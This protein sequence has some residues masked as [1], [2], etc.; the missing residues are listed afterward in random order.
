VAGEHHVDEVERVCDSAVI[1]G[2]GRVLAA[3]PLDD[4]R[5]RVGGWHVEVVTGSDRLA[6]ALTAVGATVHAEDGRLRVEGI[7]TAQPIRDAIADLGLGLVRLQRRRLS[8]EDVFLEAGV[9][10][11][12]ADAEQ[13]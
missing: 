3:G 2:A 12:P 8:L 10:D 7:D 13:R 5:A 11:R 9:Y 6:A 4:L 1:L